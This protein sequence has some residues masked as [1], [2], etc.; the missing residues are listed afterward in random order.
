M[1]I[2][3]DTNVF[4]S[5]CLTDGA[6]NAVIAGCFEGKYQPLMGNALF[7]EYEDVLGR[8]SLFKACRLNVKERS[9]L[10][11]IFLSYCQWVKIYYQW[12]PNLRDEGDNHLIELAVAGRAEYLV[13]SNL[14]DLQSGQLKFPQVQF[15]SPHSF[16]KKVQT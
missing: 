16:L 12:R 14:K 5:A 7:A 15:L 4:V 1:K 10:L 9:E 8:A 11:D 2:V 13:S 6:P 3:V